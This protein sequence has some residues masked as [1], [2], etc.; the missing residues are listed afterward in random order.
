MA[1]QIKEGSQVSRHGAIFLGN[2]GKFLAQAEKNGAYGN[3]W[4]FYGNF[5]GILMHLTCFL[6]L[7]TD[8]ST[9]Q[10]RK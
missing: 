3:L 5:M 4:E 2:V 8:Q 9:E 7:I 1:S 6:F 10:I